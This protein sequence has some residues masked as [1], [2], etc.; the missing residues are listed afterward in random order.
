MGM[1]TV[2]R[3]FYFSFRYIFPSSMS[4]FYDCTNFHYHQVAGE[5][6]VI[7]VFKFLLSDH[8]SDSLNGASHLKDYS[9]GDMS[10]YNVSD[11]GM[12]SNKIAGP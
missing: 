8:L 3:I 6:S 9:S 7:K 10:Q 5:L 1:M 12:C 4:G 2:I 11:V